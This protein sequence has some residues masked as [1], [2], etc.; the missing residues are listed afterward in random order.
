MITDAIAGALL[1]AMSWLVSLL[2][3]GAPLGLTSASGMW[4]GYAQFNTFLPLTELLAGIGV[5]L[6]V[7]T[8]I[9][10]YLAFR[11]VRGWLPFL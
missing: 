3:T 9:L 4:L 8:A 1:A 7:N 5:F 2:P 6:L 11:A 10:G